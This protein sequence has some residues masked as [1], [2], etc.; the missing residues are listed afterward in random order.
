VAASADLVVNIVTKLSGDGMQQA[1]KSTSKFRSGL[2]S[3]SKVAG[4]ALLGIGAA[5]ISAANAAAEDAK[6]QALLANSMKNSAGATQAQIAQT[7]DWID[8]Q[9]RAT[10]VT[11]DELRPALATLVRATGD[12][13]KSQA[14]LKTAMDVSAAT[15]KPLEAVTNAM[16]KGFTGNTAA[17]SR[18]VPGI[19]KA[20]IESGNFGRVMD[21]VAQKTGG[22]AAAAADT[23]AGRMKRF[24]NA[25]GETQ[26][27][28]GA[29]LLPALT[30]LTGVLVK[31]GQ[32]AQ[33]HG[34]MFTVVAAGVAILAVAIIALNTALSIYNTI[35][36][37]TAIVSEAAWAAT[38][39]PIL[40]VVA[41]VALVVAAIVILWKK[42]QTFRT[43]VLAV[44]KAI[45][46]GAQAT[47]RFIVAMWNVVAAGAKRFAAIAK[48]AWGAIRATASAVGSAVRT[49]W[50]LVWSAITLYL[51]AYAAVFRLVF[52]ALRSVVSAVA[53][54]IREVWRNLWDAL[55]S[56]AQGFRE[57]MAGI[58]EAIKAGAS[59]LGAAISKPFDTIWNA[60]QRVISAVE[61]L[62]SALGRIHVP[63]ISLPHIPG[64]GRALPAPPEGTA[65][66]ATRA[67]AGPV[68][69]A[70]GHP[71]AASSGGLV[72]NIYGAVDPEGTARQVRRLLT[73][74]DRRIG[75]RVT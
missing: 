17:I 69:M 15:G 20:A 49:I 51:R 73:N 37:I 23:A 66:L 22:A 28:A 68:P 30:K 71:R 50:R 34:T 61:S 9:S 8:A 56:M 26:E 44:W 33:D 67:V 52:S 14:A 62:I 21:E 54:W 7:E 63:K 43:I 53:S 65:G 45:K 1:E 25:L 58:W 16:A 3:A 42:S 75:L 18:L 24:Q 40:L 27:A 2:A 29:V 12:V 5:A 6:S 19:S 32:W 47:G 11:D 39:G 64:L 35:T 10:G 55:G 4:V 74:H 60:I 57:K 46:T 36:A 31:V 59:T 48:A 70:G 13:T 72:I 38:L 41:A